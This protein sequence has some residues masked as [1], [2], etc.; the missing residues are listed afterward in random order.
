MEADPFHDVMSVRGGVILDRGSGTGETFRTGL[1]T[2]SMTCPTISGDG[3][4]R[5]QIAAAFCSAVLA[6][7]ASSSLAI[8]QQKT[9]KACLKEWRTNKA[10]S[11]ANGVA[12]KAYVAHCRGG[13]A[14]TQPAAAAATPAPLVAGSRNAAGNRQVHS[15]IKDLMESIIDPSADA[16]WGAVGTVIDTD[17]SHESFPKTPEE[18]LDVRRAAVR[19]VEGANLL[20][21]PGREAAPVGTKSEVPGVELEPAQITA[22]IKKNRKS[23]DAFAKALQVLG[24]EALRASDAKNVVLLMDAGGRME[25]VCEGCHKAFWYPG[26]K[27]PSTRN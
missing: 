20:M 3:K 6:F 16:L 19:I 26:E 11:Q 14:P 12:K 25:D 10:T 21:V 18:W 9:A 22:L 24:L 2:A 5:R 15:T 7:M 27:L 8:A 23:F 13:G 4:M 17:G 1:Q